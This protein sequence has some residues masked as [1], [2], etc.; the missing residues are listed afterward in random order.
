PGPCGQEPAVL[1]HDGLGRTLS[2]DFDRPMPNQN[3]RGNNDTP[4]DGAEA[5][6]E[7]RD[8]VHA[9]DLTRFQIDQLAA[10]ARLQTTDQKCYGIAI[11]ELLSRYYG[12]GLHHS[13]NYQNLDEL[14]ERGL[15]VRRDHDGRTNRYDL[16]PA[17]RDLL[18]ERVQWLG[19]QIGLRLVDNTDCE[20]QHDTPIV[21]DEGG[22]AGDPE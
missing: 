22:T 18:I 7:R 2:R 3:T 16:T 11:E 19:D 10:I 8:D 1:A 6:S 13:R 4:H 5:S 12:T 9:T 21:V 17:G 14:I 15:V 20:T